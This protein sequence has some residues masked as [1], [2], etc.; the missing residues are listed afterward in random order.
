MG[1]YAIKYLNIHVDPGVLLV[2]N[3]FPGGRNHSQWQPGT[4]G[5]S[6]AL[7]C[8]WVCLISEGG[9]GFCLTSESL[10]KWSREKPGEAGSSIAFLEKPP[11]SS[12]WPDSAEAKLSEA[13]LG[14]D[15]VTN[16]TRVRA[17]S[18][19]GRWDPS[20]NPCAICS[21]VP[22]S[23]GLLLSLFIGQDTA[24]GKA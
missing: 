11:W 19:S 15:V 21:A 18:A 4:G 13:A 20:G 3:A 17:A 23:V 1:T 14:C 10:R 7:F 24:P 5:V 16:A 2:P 6:V 12:S 22:V 9:D 8:L